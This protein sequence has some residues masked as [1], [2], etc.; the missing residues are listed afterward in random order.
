[1]TID[2]IKRAFM[3]YQHD[4]RPGR[5][6]DDHENSWALFAE[7]LAKAQP[8]DPFGIETLV[9]HAT[10]RRQRV[11][12]ECVVR[13]APDLLA[14]EVECRRWQEIIGRMMAESDPMLAA[15]LAREAA[16]FDLPRLMWERCELLTLRAR[17]AETLA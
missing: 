13:S 5:S 9:R 11:L 6:E 8:S 15:A 4:G 2:D 12:D 17:L 3:A 7:H 14:S 1:M 10:E 16:A